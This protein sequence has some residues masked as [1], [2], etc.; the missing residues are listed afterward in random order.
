ME[1]EPAEGPPAQG[2]SGWLR[3]TNRNP[4][5]IAAIRRARRVLPG[6][7]DFGDPLSAAG[8]SGPQTAARAAD[9]LMPEREAATRE[10]S[11]ATLQ[12]W[13][14]ITERVSGRPANAE[15]TLV[16]TDL[17][18]FSSWALDAGDDATLRLLRR[19]AQAAEPPV[20]DSGGQIVKRMGDGMMAVFTEP[21]TAVR[22]TVEALEAV[23]TIEVQGYTPRMR[24]GIHTG[25]PQRI[26]SDWLGVDVNVAARVMERATRGGLI[27]SGQTLERI[28]A[29]EMES[30]GVSAKR[31][32]RPVFAPRQQGVPADL[33]M[34]RISADRDQS[35]EEEADDSA[36]LA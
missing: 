33:M 26:G 27:V 5:I 17:V 16:F 19:V 6:D 1:I 13:Q 10:V 34:Y 9:R 36:E 28:S 8:D 31:V 11:L 24:A 25:R 15:V 4:D 3:N 32:R 2:F 35:G 12:L 14:A 7:P 30:L 23:K 29:E 20:L 18:S 21:A 22:A